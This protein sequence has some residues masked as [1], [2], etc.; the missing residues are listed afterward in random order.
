MFEYYVAGAGL[1]LFQ[2]IV[3]SALWVVIG[4][5]VAAFFRRILG[6]EKTRNFFGNGTKR[7]L[8]TG[9]LLGMLIPVCSLGVI[10]IVREMHRA[11]VQGGTIIA[12]GLT[13]PLFNPLSVLYGLT[14]S[15]PIAIITFS[16]CSLLIV[17]GLGFLW[18]K[19]NPVELKETK[20]KNQEPPPAYG[21]KRMVAMIDSWAREIAGPASLYILIGILGS[22]AVAAFL[23]YGYLQL[24]LEQTD[25]LAP[26]KV[27][28][29][30]IPHL[31]DSATGH[32]SD[33]KY[34]SAWKFDWRRIRLVDSRRRRQ[35][36]PDSVFCEFDGL[37]ENSTIRCDSDRS[38]AWPGLRDQR[39][40]VSRRN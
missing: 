5:F 14:L 40:V 26:V 33:W 15:D 34:V 38:H 37:Q 35:S 11:K 13:A 19:F 28:S 10:P 22:A 7:G 21:I 36:R 32:E 30:A 39:S 6:A 2:V 8:V 27:T 31:H 23:P 25:T 24:G 12:F 29:V 4:F 20:Q 1:R 18:D 9:W 3:Y 17:T 16:F